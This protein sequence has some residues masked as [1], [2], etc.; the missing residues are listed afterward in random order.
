[1]SAYG[2][3]KKHFALVSAVLKIENLSAR[4]ALD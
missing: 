3:V 2:V 1:M 4:K